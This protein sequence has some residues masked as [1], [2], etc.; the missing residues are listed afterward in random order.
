MNTRTIGKL[1]SLNVVVLSASVLYILGRISFATYHHALGIDF[2]ERD[3][4]SVQLFLL[5][6]F[7][8]IFRGSQAATLLIFALAPFLLLRTPWERLS[9]L[10][11]KTVQD[12]TWLGRLGV[13]YRLLD[14]IRTYSLQKIGHL[15]SYRLGSL[16]KIEM[17]PFIRLWMVFI[18]HWLALSTWGYEDSRVDRQVDAILHPQNG[19]AE[20]VSRESN[21]QLWMTLELLWLALLWWIARRESLGWRKHVLMSMLIATAPLYLITIARYGGL[22]SAFHSTFPEINLCKSRNEC[23]AQNAPAKQRIFLLGQNENI[24]AVL[25]LDNQQ[26]RVF[27]IS[28]D[29]MPFFQVIGHHQVLQSSIPESKQ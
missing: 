27:G 14:S 4:D 19:A 16:Q 22:L 28:K 1:L 26:R 15:P 8:A 20:W 17:L 25:T 9:S 11:L 12:Q 18:V 13:V 23:L 29:N 24:Y 7:I 10:K 21:I 5:V 2:L 3:S 6:G